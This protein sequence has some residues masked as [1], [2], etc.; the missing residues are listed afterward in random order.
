MR[1]NFFIIIFSIIMVIVLILC[2]RIF[3]ELN[4]DDKFYFEVKW[5]FIKYQIYPTKEKS[6]EEPKE[7]TEK[8]KKTEKSKK[9]EKKPNP[10]KAFYNNQ[11]IEGVVEL[12]ESSASA[13]SG[14]FK[15]IAKA[16]IVNNLFVDMTISGEDSAKTAL[17]Y[18][19]M[20]AILYPAVGSIYSVMK[21]QKYHVNINPDFINSSNQAIFNVAFS[22]LPIRITNAALILAVQL[23]FKVMLKLFIGSR[24][25]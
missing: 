11:G 1:L 2:I 12:I 22:F 19:K 25:K 4:Y 24:K 23:I 5:L 8:I 6:K 15:R 10:I 13:I 14:M 7:Q 9:T 20:C 17:K 3:V 18:G 21:I 16:I